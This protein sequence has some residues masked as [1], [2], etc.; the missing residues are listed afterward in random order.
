MGAELRRALSVAKRKM[1]GHV[2][3]VIP[4][5]FRPE[6]RELAQMASVEWKGAKGAAYHSSLSIPE[7]LSVLKGYRPHGGSQL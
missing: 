6:F 4:G 1:S 5:D 7:L 2:P 3:G